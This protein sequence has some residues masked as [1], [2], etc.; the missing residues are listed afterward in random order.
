MT[1]SIATDPPDTAAG[2]RPAVPWLTVVTMGALM[3]F[4]DD[5]WTTSLR[6]AF[7]A[8]ER[9]QDPFGS[10]LR[11]STVL[12]PT[13]VFAVM[14][15]LLLALRLFGQ[16]LR[17]RRSTAVTSLLIAGAGTVVGLA[18]LV[19]S[20]ARDYTVQS[21]HLL[22]MAAMRVQCLT[23]D[24]LATQRQATLSVQERSVLMGAGLLALTNVVAVGWVVAVCGGRLRVSI[25]R[26]APARQH[27]RAQDLRILLAAG[28]TGS[29]VIHAAVVPEHLREWSA[30]G[31]FF[32]ALAGGELVVA[33]AL[34]W[35]R[36]MPALVA[37]VILSVCPLLLWLCSRTIGLPLG[38]DRW[39]P[40]S[41]GL[42]DVSACLLEVTTSSLAFILVRGRPGL[43]SRPATVA[44]RRWLPLVAVLAVT[45]IGLSGSG[46]AATQTGGSSHA[47][48]SSTHGAEA[49][50]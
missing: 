19:V 9:T 41:I 45:A 6:G 36:G 3:S 40:E 29:A 11:E 32:V 47:Q 30:A 15:A 28:L 27:T 42:A 24:C 18:A 26:P 12:V 10:W 21:N 7:G 23:G 25:L 43:R 31:A 14:A 35:R 48:A 34:A 39:V 20:T 49:A 38:P 2:P 22:A 50:S 16:V 13:F 33:A 4:A 1:A 17:T 44:H 5:Y 37:A 8:I 46:L